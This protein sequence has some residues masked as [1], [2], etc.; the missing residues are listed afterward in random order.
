[1]PSKQNKALSEEQVDHIIR[2]AWC[3]RT[4]FEAIQEKTQFAENEVIALMRT[5]LKRKSFNLWRARVSGRITKHRKRF[6][7]EQKA[8]HSD[9]DRI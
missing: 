9:C 2:M 4:S 6:R 5:K 7:R 3:D 8:R 1:V